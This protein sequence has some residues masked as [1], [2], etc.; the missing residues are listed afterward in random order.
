MSHRA[1]CI[2]LSLWSAHEAQ[3]LLVLLQP[4]PE[5]VAERP[6]MGKNLGPRRDDICWTGCRGQMVW[7]EGVT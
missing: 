1:L 7:I 5:S 2:C 6:C 4:G 3:S